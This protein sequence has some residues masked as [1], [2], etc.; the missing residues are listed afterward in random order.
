[1]QRQSQEILAV[2]SQ[3]VESVQLD[4]VE[5]GPEAHFGVVSF[6]SGHEFRLR[7]VNEQLRNLISGHRFAE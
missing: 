3:D 1:V 7:E 2:G 6:L 5:I 4:P